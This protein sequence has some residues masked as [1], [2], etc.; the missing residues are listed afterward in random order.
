MRCLPG[1]VLCVSA[2]ILVTA[3]NANLSTTTDDGGDNTSLDASSVTTDGGTSSSP[4][5][6]TAALCTA[7]NVSTL[8]PYAL[9]DSAWTNV[10][11]TPAG[12]MQA[13]HNELKR[14]K[15]ENLDQ[16]V[17]IRLAPGAYAPTDPGVGELYVDA[18]LRSAT[19]PVLVEA[20]DKAPNATRLSQGF[21]LVG[22]SY[23]AFD[24]VTV[25]PATLGTFRQNGPCTVDGNCF[26]DAPKPLTAQAGFHIS[27]TAINPTAKGQVGGHLDYAVYGR[28]LPSNNIVIRRTTVQNVFEDN[29]ASARE[30]EGGGSDGIKFN[31]VQDVWIIDSSIRQTSRHGVDNVAVHGACFIGNTISQT[32]LGLG[33]EAKG[34]SVDITYDGNV[35][36]DVRKVELGGEFTDAT[37][38][39]STEE[40]GT[41]EHYAYEAR[42]TI[43]RNNIILDARE[44][45]L[46][47]SGCHDCAAVGNTVF[48]RT[49]FDTSFGG[50]DAVREV[51]SAINY[52]GAGSEC[53][54]LNGDGVEP[55]WGVGP[56]P[57]DLVTKTGSNGK[58]RVFANAR[59]ALA[60]NVLVSMGSLWGASLN[61]YNHPNPTHSFGLTLIDYNYWY[62]GAAAL[63]S[64]AD[65]GWL[66]EGANS[67]YT[68]ASANPNPAFASTTVDTTD[69]TQL[70]TRALA[71]MRPSPSSPLANHGVAGLPGMS[72][73]D[74]ANQ[75][76]PTLP[77]TGALEP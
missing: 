69:P 42:R 31:Q 16:P 47:F 4:H 9:A 19:A 35:F 57:A 48:F 53:A 26:H 68:G 63:D 12:G 43:A 17:R 56:Y 29:A 25:G 8:F 6:T 49:G 50:G 64:Q 2:S 30:D 76:R 23:L 3:C 45:A 44:G 46:E 70:R 34:G 14:L 13:L 58:S 75:P 41:A 1:F 39:W 60:N 67:V 71:A 21:N 61:P 5:T 33:V 11:L 28:Y 66:M 32:G 72:A 7:A 24:G 10:D 38:Y 59:N 37:Y 40:P 36:W 27:G 15:T 18:L 62:N 20:T 54:P 73:F 55:C 52:D 65:P 22:I 74:A 77:A 51:D